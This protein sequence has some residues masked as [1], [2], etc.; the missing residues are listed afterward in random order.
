MNDLPIIDIADKIIDA[1]SKSN[2][3]IIKAPTGSGKS[4]Q[5]PQML[6]DRTNPPGKILVLQPRRL[7]ARMLASRVAFE[8][9]GEVGEEIG[10]QTRFE[11]ASSTSTRVL[12]ITEG[13]LPR[14]LF[15][16]N[17]LSSV[18]VVIFDEFHERSLA[19]D[20]ALALIRELQQT[21]RPD[22]KII[23]MS[24][25]LE[26]GLLAEYLAGA[27]L[28]FSEGRTYPVT[29]KYY[30]EA[31]KLDPWI[32]AVNATVSLIREQKVEGDILIFMPG[33]YEIRKTANLLKETALGEPV[34]IQLLYGELPSGQQKEVMERSQKRKIIIS[35]NIAE[36]SL[37]IPGV[38]HVIDSGL[39][40]INRFDSSRG[41][42][43]LY[44]E[45]ISIDSAEQRSGRAGR[46]APGSCIR[47]WSLADQRNRSNHTQPEILRVDLSET[48]LE[49]FM[50]GYNDMDSFP[51]FEKPD[52]LSIQSALQILQITGAV[53]SE[54][55]LTDDGRTMVRLPMPPRLSRLMIESNR[56][57]VTRKGA[58]TAALLSERPIFSGTPEFPDDIT[59]T[60]C[61][62]DLELLIQ[63]INRVEISQYDD[64]TCRKLHVNVSAVR[65]VTRTA[66]YFLQICRKQGMQ[67]R[68]HS[69]DPEHLSQAILLAFSDRLAKRRDSGTLLCDLKN[70]KRGELS[71]MSMARGADLFIATTIHELKSNRDQTPRTVLSNA[72]S[73]KEQWLNQFLADRLSTN[74]DLVWNSIRQVVES[75]IRTECCGV[76][77]QEKDNPQIDLQKGGDFLADIIIQKGL[78]LNGWNTEVDTFINRVKWVKRLFPEQNLPL[79]DQD[80]YSLI[81][82]ELCR[83]KVR[84]ADVKDL[85]I[86][87]LVKELLSWNQL[88]FIDTVAPVCI[89]L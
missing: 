42:N 25:T 81:I 78:L 86:I 71:K 65:Q 39:V 30:S 54:G 46:E 36:T 43:T 61:G 26:T 73:I 75:K 13:I 33:V 29:I 41:F 22:L 67:T 49:L 57:G 8:R 47:L 2:R 16:D 24:A 21:Y 37:T 88:Q 62:S 66:A 12:F 53:S 77:I 5:I 63:I 23:V 28:V 18:S 79:F 52:Q 11:S 70:G 3:L 9:G 7:A 64:D 4:T 31:G 68:D 84:Y 27:Q 14:L 76:I 80:D 55:E 32:A 34:S 85:P 50:L 87:S 89:S 60:I 6:L 45:K 35:T 10:F 20:L 1:V 40:R 83:D 17:K 56:R 51:W 74:T 59:E 15:S 72:C 82:H 58:L 69:D 48:V 44:V 19:S 38:R